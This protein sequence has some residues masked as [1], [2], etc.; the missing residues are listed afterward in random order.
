MNQPLEGYRVLDNAPWAQALT[1][2]IL[3]DLG[4]EVIKVEDNIGGDPYRALAKLLEA[5]QGWVGRNPYYE[6]VNRN[7]KSITVNLKK[8]KGKEIIYKLVEKSDVYIQN[9]SVGVA[10]KLGMDY[11]TL[12]RYNPR[13]IY[14]S[15]TGWGLKGPDSKNAAYDMM[16]LARSG[17]M[18]IIGD[19]GTR[20]MNI[21]AVLA[22]HIGAT[23][24]AFAVSIALLM[25]ERTG[26]GRQVDTSLLGSMVHM[27]GNNVDFR[28]I[29]GKEVQGSFRNR[30]ANPLWNLYKCK[31]EKWI[32]LGLL[33][34]DRYWPALCHAMGLEQYEKDPRFENIVVRAK[35]A[36]EM[37][38]ILDKTFATKT[39]AE[40]IDIL[41]KGAGLILEPVNNFSDVIEDP[42]VWANDYIIEYEHPNY[43]KVPMVGFPMHFSDAT[44]SVRLPPPEYG[45]HTE[46]VLQNLLGYDWEYMTKLKN[47]EVI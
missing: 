33:Q 5:Q 8:D 23:M 4:A 19:P 47:E 26:K 37:V 17:I 30:A 39:R 25:R 14:A 7:K 9:F 46:E 40:W 12:S 20:P 18:T 22:D 36:A 28:L 27:L 31:D 41:R 34:A 21:D 24:S 44:S 32:A 10:D 13:L 3:G 16:A 15:S 1:G 45:Q 35:N 38:S 11:A 42:Q 2:Q 6:H 29:T 43:G